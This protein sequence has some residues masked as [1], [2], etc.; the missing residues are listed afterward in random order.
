MS[1]KRSVE[2]ERRLKRLSHKSPWWRGAFYSDRKGRYLRFYLSDW[3]GDS[4]YAKYL[5]SSSNRRVRHHPDLLQH[6]SYRK[7][8]DLW[9]MLF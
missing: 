3:G 7:A 5:K 1:H 2:D 9:W 6:K 4:K 8:Y